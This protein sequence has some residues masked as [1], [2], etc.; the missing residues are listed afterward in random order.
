MSD[1]SQSGVPTPLSKDDI[2][3]LINF[4]DVQLDSAETSIFAALP[5]GDGRDWL[6][7][8]PGLGR[9]LL[10]RIERERREVL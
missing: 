2:R 6:L 5:A 1:L 8:N 9:E 10:A 7:A 3:L 4:M